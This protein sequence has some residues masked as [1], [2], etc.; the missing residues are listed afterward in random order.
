[1]EDLE[2][3]ISILRGGEKSYHVVQPTCKLRHDINNQLFV[4]IAKCEHLESL[5]PGPLVFDVTTR[6]KEIAFGISERMHSDECRVERLAAVARA[7]R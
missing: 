2:L 7:A 6:I 1:M 3:N 4:I 5:I